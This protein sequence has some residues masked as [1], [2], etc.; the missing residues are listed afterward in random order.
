MFAAVGMHIRQLAVC[1]RLPATMQKI[2][3]VRK[4]QLYKLFYTTLVFSRGFLDHGEI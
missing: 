1:Q 3:I 4:S 2:L